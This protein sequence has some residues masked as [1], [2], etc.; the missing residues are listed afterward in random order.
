MGL[1]FRKSFKLA[2]GVRLNMSGSGF[3]WTLGPRGAS[4]NFSSRGTRRNIDLPGGFSFQ[5]GVGGV[6]RSRPSSAQPAGQ[7]KLQI[8]IK[9]QDDGTLAFYDADENPLPSH[10]VEMAKEQQGDAIKDLLARGCAEM[11]QK[12]EGLE[13]IHLTTPRPDQAPI[14]TPQP[15]SGDPPIFPF[16]REFGFAGTL[17][18]WVKRRL[19]RENEARVVEY[20][21]RMRTWET[22]KAA[23]D[24][25][26][27]EQRRF[28]EDGLGSNTEAMQALLMHRL[29]AIQWPR[30]TA[31]QLEISPDGQR[32]ALDVDLPEIE[33]FPTKIASYS[34][35]GWKLTVKDLSDTKIAQL[36][37]R[38]VHGIGFRLVGEVFATLPRVRQVTLSGY[39]QRPSPATGHIEDEY[40]YSVRVAREQ[41]TAIN[42]SN[43]PAIDVCEVF[44]RFELRRDSGRASKLRA[45]DPFPA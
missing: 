8:S 13:T 30:E 20:Q 35:R 9:T 31:V 16:M 3:S 2:P 11:N 22:M 25:R 41:W 15:F 26:E 4:M 36:Y 43:L 38:H 23:H 5:D 27:Q 37:M 40:L 29:E 44:A 45:I 32:V 39:S 18:P 24:K 21:D 6:R 19:Q 33:D 42:F 10:L 1:R 12:M 7:E 34:G 17:F 28:I 14:F